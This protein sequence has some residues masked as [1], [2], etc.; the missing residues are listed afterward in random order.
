MEKRDRREREEER[1]ER[2]REERHEREERRREREQ[3]E[4]GDDPARHASIIARRWLGSPPPTVERYRRALQQWHALPGAGPRPATVVQTPEKP[5]HEHTERPGS[6]DR[7]S[8][9]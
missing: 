5:V 1:R 9:L 2:V 3:K 4:S 6:T 7:G 8:K